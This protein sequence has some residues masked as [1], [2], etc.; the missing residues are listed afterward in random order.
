MRRITL[1]EEWII[2]KSENILVQE[3]GKEQANMENSKEEKST[4]VYRNTN[5]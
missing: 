1:C 2:A 3:S 5:G 4:K